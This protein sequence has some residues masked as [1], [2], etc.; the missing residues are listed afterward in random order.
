MVLGQ[1]DFDMQAFSFYPNPVTNI[2]NIRYNS[3]ITAI[4]VH[5]MLG[6]QVLVQQ[7][8]AAQAVIDMAALQSGTYMVSITAGKAIKTIKLVKV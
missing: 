4:S 5:N 3:D 7:P 6:Q 1:D 2:L 8:N